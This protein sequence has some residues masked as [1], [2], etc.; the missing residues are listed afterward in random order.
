MFQIVHALTDC[1]GVMNKGNLPCLVISSWQFP[2][3]CGNYTITIF[4]EVPSLLRTTTLDNYTGT[5]YCNLTF[6]EAQNE[7]EIGSYLINWST[8]DSSKIIIEEDDSML[9]ALVIGVSL[10]VALFIFLTFAVKEDKPFLA[11]FFFL[12]IFI[13]TTILSFLLW[14]ITNVNSAPYESIMYLIYYVLLVVTMLMMFVVLIMLTVE[15]VKIR[16][17]AGNPV[18]HYRDNLGKNEKDQF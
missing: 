1:A 18:D 11:N 8:G 15:A 2:N 17:I 12:G 3:D 7:T 6:G 14:K 16:K 5:S 4:N 10:I 9:I 13:F